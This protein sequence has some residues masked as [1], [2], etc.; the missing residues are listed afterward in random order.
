MNGVISGRC[1]VARWPIWVA[2]AGYGVAF[3]LAGGLLLAS[4][5]F[6]ATLRGL[7]RRY[8]SA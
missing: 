2:T 1:R 6:V 4:G 3:A 8:P 7:S 5:L